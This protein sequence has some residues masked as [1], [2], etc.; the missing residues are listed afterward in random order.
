MILVELRFEG[1]SEVSMVAIGTSEEEARLSIPIYNLSPEPGNRLSPTTTRFPSL[2]KFRPD[3]EIVSV[4]ENIRTSAI[5][6][7]YGKLPAP[8]S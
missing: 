3:T 6:V 4:T 7:A 5:E 8:L 2:L 1:E